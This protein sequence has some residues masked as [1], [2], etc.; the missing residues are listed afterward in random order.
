MKLH[1][2]K[3]RIQKYGCKK[4]KIENIREHWVIFIAF[5]PVNPQLKDIW[6]QYPLMKIQ[7][8]K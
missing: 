6:I 7:D 3:E 8:R 1:V 2:F 4:K 5:T